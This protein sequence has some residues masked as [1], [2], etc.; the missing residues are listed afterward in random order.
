MVV[1]SAD[2]KS[3]P[4]ATPRRAAMDCSKI[5]ATTEN[6]NVQISA[7]PKLAPATLA[8]VIVPGPIKAAVTRSPGPKRM[9]KPF[10]IIF[11][12]LTDR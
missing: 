6:N 12:T 4:V 8:V 3:S 9:I 1:L 10:I 2:A 7:K 11:S 5:V